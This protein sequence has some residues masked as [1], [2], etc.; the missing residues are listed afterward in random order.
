ME[1]SELKNYDGMIGLIIE[2]LSD[3]VVYFGYDK[4]SSTSYSDKLYFNKATTTMVVTTTSYK[5]DN[6]SYVISVHRTKNSTY[7][8][9]R[10]SYTFVHMNNTIYSH[11]KEF[12]RIPR[13][14]KLLIEDIIKK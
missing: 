12:K 6:D 1:R 2:E 5:E 3:D 14:V 4:D 13:E 7:G 10:K 9:V 8:P 11:N